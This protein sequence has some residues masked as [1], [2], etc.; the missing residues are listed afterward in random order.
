MALQTGKLGDAEQLLMTVLGIRPTRA[1]AEAIR[2]LI[3]IAL[4]AKS[5]RQSDR[6]MTAS[7]TSMSKI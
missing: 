6:G 5:K 1:G 3:E 4:A 2:R 7:G